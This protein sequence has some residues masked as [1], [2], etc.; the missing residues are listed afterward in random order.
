MTVR[1]SEGTGG[2]DFSD[3]QR[4]IVVSG[5]SCES[6][7]AAHPQCTGEERLQES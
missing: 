4:E 2:V 5:K 6:M 1:G 7:V 3:L